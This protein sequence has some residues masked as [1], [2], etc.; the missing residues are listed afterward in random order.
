MKPSAIRRKLEQLENGCVPL[1]SC[2]MVAATLGKRRRLHGSERLR[3]LVAGNAP[4]R[5]WVLEEKCTG[6]TR[7]SEELSH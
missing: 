1:P 6:G 2:E 5:E 4:A 3:P 7:T